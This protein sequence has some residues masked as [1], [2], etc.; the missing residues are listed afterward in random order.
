MKV[1]L[2]HDDFVQEGGAE[3]L[4]AVIAS[5]W[6]SAP[7]YTSL[8]DWKKLPESIS[9]DRIITSFIQKIPF[10]SKFHKFLLPLYPLAFESFNFDNFDL[11]IS[12][13]TRFAKA[14]VTKPQTIHI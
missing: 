12:T 14:S 4:F 1:A 6:P 2:I 13:T 11:V 8:V 9:R 5:I 3:N 10:A 7:I